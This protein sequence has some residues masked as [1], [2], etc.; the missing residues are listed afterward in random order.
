MVEEETEETEPE[1]PES[2]EGKFL[3]SLSRRDGGEPFD[4]AVVLLCEHSDEG[5][6]GLIVNSQ[7]SRPTVGDLFKEFGIEGPP[8]GEGVGVHFGGPVETGRGFVL[9]SA[10]Y[11]CEGTKGVLPDVRVTIAQT[12]LQD[13]AKGRG[14]SEYLFAMGYAG[15][16]PGQLESELQRNMWICCDGDS[17]LVFGSEE[18]NE[19]WEVALRGVGAT[20]STLAVTGGQA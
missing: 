18:A 12:I 16:A 20:P 7:I 5:A 13:M 14:P 10:D 1:D 8:P 9:H 11:S 15:W 4:R 2:L 17:G 3:I 19:K 6:M